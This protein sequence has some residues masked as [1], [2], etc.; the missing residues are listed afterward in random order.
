MNKKYRVI[1]A[2]PPWYFKN[3][4][5]KG[6]GRN[7]V[8]H[9]DCM[10]IEDLSRLP[11]Y[12]WAAKD[13]VLFLWVTDPIL[14]QAIELI[15]DW[16]FKYKTVGFYWIKTNKKVDPEKMSKKSFFTGLG[17]WTRANPE[18]C[19][20]A[21]RG[22]P[23]RKAKNIPRL[24]ISPRREHSR[25]PDEVYNLIKKLCNGPYLELFA[26]KTQK[27]WD[28]WGKEKKLFDN[29]VVST[30]NRPSNMGRKNKK[31]KRIKRKINKKN[32]LNLNF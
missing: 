22:A 16:G 27:G 30:R 29:G 23:P 11:I 21:T 12:K 5:E 18:Q 24:L 2:D 26:R 32:Q 3:F 8:A 9:Y 19:L 17:Y 4:S 13:C 20:I 15:E 7:P 25:K 10:S 28:S 31:K 6:T 14:D 1:Y